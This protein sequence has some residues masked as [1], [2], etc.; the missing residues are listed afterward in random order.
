VNGSLSRLYDTMIAAIDS[1]ILPHLADDFAS[2]QA[3]GLI[4]MLRCLRA[5]TSWS[6]EFLFDQVQAGADGAKAFTEFL[7]GVPNS[8]SPTLINPARMT[9]AELEAAKD[10]S[11]REMSQAYDWVQQHRTV[12]PTSALDGIEQAYRT[13]LAH[14]LR[15]E[16]KR[17]VA[18]NFSEISTG[19]PAEAE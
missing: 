17:S 6:M 7:A 8:P 10:R 14:Q 11:N 1:Q 4:Y 3:Y 16:L 18:I 19:A 2:A 13:F 12:L 9:A 5:Q 15:A